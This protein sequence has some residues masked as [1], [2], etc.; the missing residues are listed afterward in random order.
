M[1]T[2]FPCSEYYDGLRLL[3]APPHSF[4]SRLS[5]D[6]YSDPATPGALPSSSPFRFPPCHAL[7]LRRGLRST[8]PSTLLLVAFPTFRPG[9][10]SDYSL[11]K[12]YRFIFED[13]GLVVVQ[14]TLSPPPYGGGPKTRF[15]VQGYPYGDR[16]LTG[17]KR[18]A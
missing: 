7:G 15:S 13:Y 1:Y 12:F 5:V 18:L 14:F 6:G 10:P 8:R 3:R 16:N 4:G 9:Q 11:T 17:S 2:A